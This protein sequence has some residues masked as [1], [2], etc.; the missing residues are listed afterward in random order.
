VDVLVN[1]KEGRFATLVV[2]VQ[3][4][5]LVETLQGGKTA[6]LNSFQFNHLV[7]FNSLV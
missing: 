1:D 5:D 4:A 7:D 6:I 3:A 2:A